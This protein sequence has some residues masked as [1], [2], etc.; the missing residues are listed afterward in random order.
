MEKKFIEAFEPQNTD[1]GAAITYSTTDG[2]KSF[3]LPVAVDTIMIAVVNAAVTTQSAAVKAVS[4]A[5]VAT[6][7]KKLKLPSKLSLL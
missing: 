5:K 4:A 6:M 2:R 3:S 1:Q 7:P